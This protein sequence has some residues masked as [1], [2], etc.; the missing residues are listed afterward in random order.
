MVRALRRHGMPVI[1][2]AVEMRPRYEGIAYEA[3]P[4]PKLKPTELP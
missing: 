1:M 2:A 4:K 3:S